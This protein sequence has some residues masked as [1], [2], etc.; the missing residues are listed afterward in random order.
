MQKR[1]VFRPAIMYPQYCFNNQLN[2]L[3]IAFYYIFYCFVKRFL[4]VNIKKIIKK[5]TFSSVF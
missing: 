4:I 2:I 5:T 1:Q 3:R